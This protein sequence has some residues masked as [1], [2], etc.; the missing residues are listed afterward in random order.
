MN[1]NYLNGINEELLEKDFYRQDAI[2]LAKKLLGKILVRKINDTQKYYIITET[3]AYYG[4]E[5]K[6]CHCSKGKTPRT[7]VM[8]LEGGTIYV[9]LIYG[10]YWML[11]I[12]SGP[13][14]HPEAVLIRGIS[15]FDPVKKTIIKEYNGPG[16]A[17]KAL[18][19]N[20][21]N[22]NGGKIYLRETKLYLINALPHYK[23]NI[24]TA[25]RI[26]IDYAG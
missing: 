26:G 2:T 5:D 21:E 15:E 8:Y 10:M 19:I 22:F 9:Y 7:S 11:N 25:T 4:E 12:V 6:A 18:M 20:K 14:N 24:S 23:I 1:T 16:K 13:E 17:G 3:E